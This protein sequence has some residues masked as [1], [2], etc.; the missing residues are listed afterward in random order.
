MRRTVRRG[1]RDDALPGVSFIMMTIARWATA[2]IAVVLFVLMLGPFQGAEQTL[3][4][5]DKQAHGVG[6]ALITSALFMSLPNQPR[7]R[8]ALVALALGGL[9]EVIQAYTGRSGSL[10]DLGAD[11]VGILLVSSLWPR[12]SARVAGQTIRSK[13]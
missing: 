1:R 5:S 4:L 9:V 6:F 11:S 10:L 3:G 12:G 2:L 13:V 8:L 7:W